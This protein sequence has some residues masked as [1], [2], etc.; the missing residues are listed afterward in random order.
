MKVWNDA[1]MDGKMEGG[2]PRW[3][4]GW[5]DESIREK[6]HRSG[7]KLILALQSRAGD[8]SFFI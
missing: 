6:A 1:C 2:L 5:T 8:V 4:D 7:S 3:M